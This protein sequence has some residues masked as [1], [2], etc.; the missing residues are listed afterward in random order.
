MKVLKSIAIAAIL[1]IMT[2]SAVAQLSFGPI[3][4]INRAMWLP[5]DAFYNKAFQYTA[6][7]GVTAGV[8][9]DLQFNDHLAIQGGVAFA[10]K[11]AKSEFFDRLV[12]NYLEVPFFFRPGFPVGQ[13]RLDALMGPSF[14]YAL[15][16][17]SHSEPIKF[18]KEAYNRLNFNIEAGLQVSYDPGDRLYVFVSGRYAIGLYPDDE[19]RQ[20]SIDFHP[21]HKVF[22]KGVVFAAGVMFRL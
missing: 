10:R 2:H 6:R 5:D 17:K 1:L 4:G 11:G 19:I 7:T 14:G 16:G 13:Y 20:G 15:S 8:L 3:A 12:V 18:G 22:N 21:K 9:L